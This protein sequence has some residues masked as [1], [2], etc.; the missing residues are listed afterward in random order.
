MGQSD[1]WVP[2]DFSQQRTQAS[3]A[4][5]ATRTTA[6]LVQNTSIVR[7]VTEYIRLTVLVQG[8]FSSKPATFQAIS[9]KAMLTSCISCNPQWK[10]HRMKHSLQIRSFSNLSCCLHLSL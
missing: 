9:R 2:I 8:A 4:L 10:R 1:A 5:E 3:E 6:P 7:V